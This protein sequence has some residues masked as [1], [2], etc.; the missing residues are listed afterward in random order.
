MGREGA[1]LLGLNGNVSP[2]DFVRLLEGR[3]NAETQLGK[4]GAGGVIEH[5][6][7]WDFTLS[8]PKSVSVLALVG[9]DKRLIAA[10]IE[11]CK[12][13]MAFVEREYAF[14]R[15]S[16]NG[17]TEYSKVDNLLYASYVH[18]ESRKHDPQLHSHN[19]VMNAVMDSTGQWRSLETKKC[20][21]LN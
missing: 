12:E 3:I 19:V 16:N 20:L 8:A 14:T 10:H 9:G 15:V 17:N 18:T 11:S 1:E 2:E 21:K 13:A 7:A 4:L 5:V 6:P